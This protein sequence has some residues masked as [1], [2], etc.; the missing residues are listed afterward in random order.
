V[1]YL[2]GSTGVERG[3]ASL[4]DVSVVGSG[5]DGGSGSVGFGARRGVG[6]DG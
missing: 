2:R 5:G 1:H 3:D 6:T 4:L